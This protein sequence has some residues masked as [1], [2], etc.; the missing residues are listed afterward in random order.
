MSLIPSPNAS[1]LSVPAIAFLVAAG[2]T[3]VVRAMARQFKAV[4]LPKSDRWHQKPT[5][6]FGGIAIYVS[7][8][9][10]ILMFLPQSRE[11]WAV[12]GAS[13]GLF[14]L[15]FVDDLLQ[16]KPYQKLIGQLLAASAIVYMGLVLPWTGSFVA[17]M[18]ITFFWLVGI[19]N[20]INMLDNMDGLAAGVSAI[21]SFFLAANFFLNGQVTEALM[22][23]IFAGG[24]AG[25]LIYNHSPASI[26]MGDCGSMFIGFFLASTALLS[27]Q[28][29]GG[30]SRSVI[31]VLAVPVLLLCIP[32]FDTTF[33]TVMR[34]LAGRAASQGGRDHTSH[35][36]VALG[37]SERHAV[38]MIYAFASLAGVLAL[39]VRQ[40]QLDVSLAAIAGFSTI[41]ALLGVYLAKVR[42]YSDEEM[43]VAQQKPLVSLLFDLSHKRRIFEVGLDLVFIVLAQYSAYAFVFGPANQA[44]PS[45]Q[46]F[47]QTLPVI[48]AVKLFTFLGM[49]MY[50]GM[51]RYASLTDMFLFTKTVTLSSATSVLLVVVLFRFDGF[52]RTVFLL[53]GLFLLFLCSSGRFAFRFLRKVLP[54]PHAKTGKR[55]L[56]FGAGDGGELTFRELVNNSELQYIPV[57]FVDDDPLKTGKLRHGLQVYSGDQSLADICT[58]KR[59][60][61]VF[62]STL[63]I[64]MARL[65]RIVSECESAGVAVKRLRIE[66]DQIADRE[67]GWVLPT[68]EPGQIGTALVSKG[69][70]LELS[71]RREPF[72]GH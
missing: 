72:T 65:R 40:V 55:V 5:A 42:V 45:W 34:K 46:L 18:F 3:P 63:R 9:S 71:S 24:L 54:A 67:V 53:D 19:T 23:L 66:I 32:I 31:A 60:Q 50:R 70:L 12:I 35:R 64:S 38:W 7:V 14:I 20:A 21:A 29:G 2:V 11:T 69:P 52:S 16:I 26:F 17:N 39:L 30:R 10:T 58:E 37:L 27:A 41:L 33:V 51:W 28:G 57:A 25:F 22:L 1:L 62:L 43:A 4:A 6:M 68:L 49:G 44:S 13:T 8:I 56:I 36:L 15:G 47:L 61:E 48:V 59:V